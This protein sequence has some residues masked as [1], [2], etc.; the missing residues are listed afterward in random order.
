MSHGLPE[1]PEGGKAWW[2]SALVMCLIFFAGIVSTVI[3]DRVTMAQ[4][5]GADAMRLA[6]LETSVK[7]LEA[8]REEHR[9][10]ISEQWM[11]VNLRLQHIDDMLKQVQVTIEHRR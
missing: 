8:S 9:K 11:A 1:I 7:G 10:V 3:A 6:A 2:K 4:S 5:A